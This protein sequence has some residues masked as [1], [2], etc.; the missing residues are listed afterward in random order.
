MTPLDALDDM[1]DVP[2]A[3]AALEVAAVN[4]AARAATRILRVKVMIGF[5]YMM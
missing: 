3:N 4:P 1:P 2:W 5:L